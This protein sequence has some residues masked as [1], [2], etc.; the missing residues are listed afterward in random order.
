MGNIYNLPF[1]A[2]Q[3]RTNNKYASHPM[4][5]AATMQLSLLTT[6][7]LGRPR[8]PATYALHFA[9]H[10]HAHAHALPIPVSGVC[11]GARSPQNQSNSSTCPPGL[12]SKSFGCPHLARRRYL[13]FNRSS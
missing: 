11:P 3:A 5:S 10:A 13:F 9:S 6:I 1:P 7:R 8:H 2:E 4:F 12:I